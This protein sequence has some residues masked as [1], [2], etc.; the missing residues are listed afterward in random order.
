MW[1]VIDYERGRAKRKV[2]RITETTSLPS[3]FISS[4][5]LR[6]KRFMKNIFEIW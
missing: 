6:V 4:Q 3:C 1:G 5:V 2:E